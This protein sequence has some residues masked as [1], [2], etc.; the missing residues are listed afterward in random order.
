MGS[1]TE[2]ILMSLSNIELL[3]DHL[4]MVFINK[5]TVSSKIVINEFIREKNYH[6]SRTCMISAI[7]MN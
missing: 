1:A 3:F 4:N 7:N 5:S 2:R 6:F